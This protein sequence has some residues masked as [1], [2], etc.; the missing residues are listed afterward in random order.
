MVSSNVTFIVEFNSK[1]SKLWAVFSQYFKANWP[2]LGKAISYVFGAA[3]ATVTVFYDKVKGVWK[4]LHDFLD[5]WGMLP[6]PDDQAGKK[7]KINLEQRKQ[8]HQDINDKQ[9]QLNQ[10]IADENKALNAANKKY[11][12]RSAA[13]VEALKHQ[14][15]MIGLTADEV[16]EIETVRQFTKDY[17]NEL[18]ALKS[19]LEELNK[20]P[21][22][23]K[24]EIALIQKHV[25]ELTSAYNEQLPVVKKLAAE[26]TAKRKEVEK[27]LAAQEEIKRLAEETAQ[28]IKDSKDFTYSLAESTAEA[29]R[30][31][32]SMDMNP[33][34]KN[35]NKI[36]R[37]IKAKLA[38]EIKKLNDIKTD[39]NAK[40][41]NKQVAALTKAADEAIKKQQELAAKSYEH[42]RTF[43]YG[44]KKAF[45][46]YKDDATNSAK[47]A[48]RIFNKTTSGI[49]DMIV[50]LAKTGK[51]EWKDF[52]ASI[53]EE[54]LR[55]Q[56]KILAADVF[57][58]ATKTGSD[59]AAHVL[60]NTPVGGGQQQ[61]SNGGGLLGGIGS[62]VGG[63]FGGGSQAQGRTPTI[64][65]QQR[66]PQPASGGMW[67]TVK[68]VGSALGGA[69]GGIA[70]GIGSLFS[71][72][73]AD[74][75]AIPS[76]KFGIVGER[77][78][79]MISGPANI[80]PISSGGSS[81]VTYNI[82]AVDAQSFQ[83]LVARDPSFIHAVAMQ[84]A[85]GT[86]S[87]R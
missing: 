43:S 67:D 41:I 47:T 76:G 8:L 40:E 12:E 36:S 68:S 22:K 24:E 60:R 86:P 1:L 73:F 79:E 21:A 77:G 80:T 7:I 56:I 75:G 19:K 85:K 50:N 9:Q 23:H 84:G 78:P 69:V 51:F 5:D 34:E 49:E 87:R 59:T 65:P 10:F 70:K 57:G 30:A 64:A 25:T 16:T 39:K 72:F 33:L 20:A 83:A 44:W 61:Q 53:L 63:L 3:V 32:D 82:Q 35:I 6:E 15:K 58:D 81:N 52:A 54:M 74:G 55:T 66:Q 45:Q 71:G 11:K 46:Q 37:D 17:E 42:Q 18:G 28:A 27:E 14:K 38:T 48:E 26:I 13:T 4:S 31:F 29:Q 62:L 2:E